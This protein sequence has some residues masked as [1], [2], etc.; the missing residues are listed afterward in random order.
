M[1]HPDYKKR[2]LS[3]EGLSLVTGGVRALADLSG[4]R[5]WNRDKL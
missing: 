4:V 5:P 1:S 2:V 3:D